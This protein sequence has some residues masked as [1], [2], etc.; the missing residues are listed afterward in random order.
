VGGR[1]IESTSGNPRNWILS[2]AAPNTASFSVNGQAVTTTFPYA[3]ATDSNK[4]MIV[5]ASTARQGLA[6]SKLCIKVNNG[7]IA[8]QMRNT[9]YDDTTPAANAVFRIGQGF[10]GYMRKIKIYD[11]PKMDPSM[12]LMYKTAPQCYKFHHSQPDCAIC[13]VDYNFTCYTSC[14]ERNMWDYDCKTCGGNCYT[15]SGNDKFHC[16]SCPEPRY[17]FHERCTC[18]PETC[19][20]GFFMG[21]SEYD[22]D[23]G[24]NN[25]D[26]G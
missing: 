24:N 6:L 15:C 25:V 17:R 4:W 18:C 26:D 5:Q 3:A 10:N 2:F 20:D 14:K 19:G 23:D 11:Y 12:K 7:N 1:I 13:D 22:C 16:F 8:C 9:Y 21:D